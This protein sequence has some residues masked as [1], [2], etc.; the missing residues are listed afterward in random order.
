MIGFVI[1][2]TRVREPLI[3]M[4]F[5]ANRVR[6][7]AYLVVIVLG[8]ATAAL[9]FI[10]V[11]YMQDVLGYTPLQS[12]L[13]WLP[14]TAAF[15]AGILLSIRLA[16]RW[17]PRWTILAGLAVT[18]AGMLVL[19]LIRVDGSFL[20]DVLPGTVLI[21]F[22]IGFANPALQQAG[23]TGVSEKDAGLGSGLFTTLLQLSGAIGLT[24]LMSI[25]LTATNQAGT[26]SPAAT[27]AG[28]HAAFIVATIAVAGAAATTIL[29]LT[30]TPADAAAD[31]ARS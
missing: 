13:S 4:R 14:Y 29:L 19:C 7:A 5:I 18:G 12:G 22:G 20:L 10:I 9:F 23:M 6:V 15:L 27:V 2:Q 31:S 25:A 28:Y 8:G 1:V 24:A 26:P 21:G 30:R 11:L 16:P 3:P 17:G